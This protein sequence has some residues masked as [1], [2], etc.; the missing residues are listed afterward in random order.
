[1]KKL[2]TILLFSI[3]FLTGCNGEPMTAAE[4]DAALKECEKYDLR[5]YINHTGSFGSYGIE[6]ITCVEKQ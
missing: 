3:F 4:I 5:P 2:F 1:M 6:E